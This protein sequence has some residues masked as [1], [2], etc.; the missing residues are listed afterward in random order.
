MSKK[1]I[2]TIIFATVLLLISI[3][4]FGFM[5]FQIIRQGDKL[6]IQLD[7]LASERAQESSYF[8]LIR[9]GEES[10]KDRLKIQDY[11]LKEESDSIDFLNLIEGLARQSG[12]SLKTDSLGTVTSPK[13]NSTW[14]TVSVSFSGS[15]ER[16]QN[17]V[18]L[19]ETLPYVIRLTS[20][21][22]GSL[23]S[24]EWNARVS[25]EVMIL[26]L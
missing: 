9:I 20:F 1:T 3:L 19:F 16:V 6:N 21:E 12:V 26:N 14:I 5:V 13:D 18:R 15:R 2:R 24:T 4:V 7:T 11:F 22:M 25:M 10:A 23:S 8:Q 17:F